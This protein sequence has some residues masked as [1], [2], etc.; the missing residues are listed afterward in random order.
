MKAADQLDDNVERSF[1]RVFGKDIWYLAA[2]DEG[3]CA[4]ARTYGG[5]SLEFIGCNVTD[6]FDVVAEPS[7][8]AEAVARPPKAQVPELAGAK[9]YLYAE[10][11]LYP[12]SEVDPNVRER[13]YPV[14]VPAGY[15]IVP[16][17]EPT[18]AGK[19]HA[20]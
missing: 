20:A 15:D 18:D 3:V 11:K 16:V 19:G 14:I 4:V 9:R 8:F 17:K 7:A 1:R 6:L 10:G 13:Y 2:S 12:E 5:Y